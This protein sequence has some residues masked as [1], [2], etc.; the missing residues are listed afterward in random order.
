MLCIILSRLG[1]IRPRIE[2][3]ITMGKRWHHRVE[4]DDHQ[5]LIILKLEMGTLQC[6]TVVWFLRKEQGQQTLGKTNVVSVSA[7]PSIPSGDS[8]NKCRH[9][10]KHMV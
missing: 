3:Q 5:L 9:H 7:K 6:R 2:N 10:A 4:V 8:P 1:K